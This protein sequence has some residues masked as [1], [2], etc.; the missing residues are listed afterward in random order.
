VIRKNGFCIECGKDQK[1]RNPS[2]RYCS[3]C[4]Y[5]PKHKTTHQIVDEL[6]AE[7]KYLKSLKYDTRTAEEKEAI[8]MAPYSGPWGQE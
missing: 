4:F 5:S 3:D 7:I 2:A 8:E 1:G 6:R